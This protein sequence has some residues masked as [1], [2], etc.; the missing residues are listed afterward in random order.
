MIRVSEPVRIGIVSDTFRGG[1]NETYPPATVI[2]ITTVGVTVMSEVRKIGVDDLFEAAAAGVMR[3][4]QAREISAERLVA[5]GFTVRIDLLAGGPPV[6]QQGSRASLN[7]QPE[8]PGVA[9][10]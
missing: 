10:K 7:P 6:L 2:E 4:L 3:G 1:S 9:A 8:P 5:S